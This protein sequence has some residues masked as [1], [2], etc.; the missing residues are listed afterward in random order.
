MVSHSFAIY[1]CSLTGRGS[2]LIPCH[3]IVVCLLPIATA[4]IS[5]LAP[6][7]ASVRA[8]LLPSCLLTF[9]LSF[10]EHS[11]PLLNAHARSSRELSIS[12]VENAGLH[13][14][15]RDVRLPVSHRCL[16]SYGV[17]VYYE[18]SLIL[19]SSEVQARR[20]SRLP[21]PSAYYDLSIVYCASTAP[22][23]VAAAHS[24]STSCL[25]TILLLPA[26]DSNCLTVDTQLSQ[27]PSELALEA[28]DY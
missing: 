10:D 19:S 7:H 28:I 22:Q 27:L 15:K 25:S 21:L 12:K 3:L 16:Q 5:S 23:M 13:K 18:T 1:R 6:P 8:L 4:R 2:S 11:R 9:S 17:A 20:F 24:I 26:I 14:T